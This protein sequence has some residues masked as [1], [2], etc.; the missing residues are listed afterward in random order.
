MGFLEL[1]AEDQRL[2]VLRVLTEVGGNAT[3]DV[4]LKQALSHF[5]H[6]VSRDMVR[7]HL[8]WLAEHS[9]VELER[10][11][12]GSGELWLATL[13]VAGLDV[14]SGARVHPGVARR[15]PE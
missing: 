10:L 13:T 14:A 2:V 8:A 3:N 5:G 15:G 7:A 6:N 9:L 4:V 11:A 12:A 1:L